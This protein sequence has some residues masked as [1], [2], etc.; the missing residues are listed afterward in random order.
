M[1]WLLKHGYE[2]IT[3]LD[4]ASTFPPLLDYLDMA[5]KHVSVIGLS[6]NLGKF[7]LWKS[8]ALQAPEPPFIYTDPDVIPDAHCPADII[9]V[10]MQALDRHPN[11]KKCGFGLR[12][13]DLPDCYAPRETVIAWE[14]QFWNRQIRS[15]DMPCPIYD[16]AIDTT[17]ALYLQ[18]GFTP[19]AIRTGFPYVAKHWT[20][21]LDSSKPTSE[22]LHYESTS[23]VS[24]TWKLNGSTSGAVR[25]F[26]T[27]INGGI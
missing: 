13:D 17:F 25:N 15:T 7:A 8:K 11:K 2:N 10:F 5:S 16:A 22:R 6:E 9:A 26:M 27:K 1:T 14:S 18:K 4:N 12:I 3:I 23:H 19:T 21:Y 20:W 24:G